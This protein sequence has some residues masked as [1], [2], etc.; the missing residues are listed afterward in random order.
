[1][2]IKGTVR[3]AKSGAPIRGALIKVRNVTAISDTDSV[4]K[5]INHDVTSGQ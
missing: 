5:P 1:M 3:D 2:G 4:D